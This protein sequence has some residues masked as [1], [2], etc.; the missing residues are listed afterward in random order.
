MF[1]KQ[2]TN[3]HIYIIGLLQTTTLPRSKSNLSLLN[4]IQIPTR[5]HSQAHPAPLTSSNFDFPSILFCAPHIWALSSFSSWPTHKSFSLRLR[6]Y[7]STAF[8]PSTHGYFFLVWY[9]WWEE[10]FQICLPPGH[11]AHSSSDFCLKRINNEEHENR[12]P[13]FWD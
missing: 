13:L 5:T 12:F 7:T 10:S 6:L 9:N 4:T 2:I 11:R 1:W 3:C 8:W